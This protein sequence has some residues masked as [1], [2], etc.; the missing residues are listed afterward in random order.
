M[1]VRGGLWRAQEEDIKVSEKHQAQDLV[2]LFCLFYGFV[3]W[4]SYNI[5]NFE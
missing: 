3:L 4:F 1:K 2:N 5:C